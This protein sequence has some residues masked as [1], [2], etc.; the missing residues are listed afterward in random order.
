MNANQQKLR[1]AIKK[2]IEDVEKYSQLAQ[3]YKTV[4]LVSAVKTK[5][6]VIQKLRKLMRGKAEFI[7][8]K[9]V[10]LQ[11]TLE[12]IGKTELSKMLEQPVYLVYTNM[13]P[14][15]FFEYLESNK[16]KVYAI[17][18]D[19]AP[20]DILIEKGPT[21]LQPGPVLSELKGAGLEVIIDKGK[22]SIKNDKVVVKKGE[23][24][25]KSVANVLR[26][27]NI[28]P[29]EIGARYISAIKDNMLF[30][31][32][33]LQTYSKKNVSDYLVAMSQ[34]ALNLSCNVSYYTKQNITMLLAKAVRDAKGLSYS[35]DLYT[36][37]HINSI[38]AKAK[39]Q[40]SAL[41]PYVKNHDN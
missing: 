7:M 30:T 36:D 40:G 35:Q 17:E 37:D 33:I 12:K 3:N 10:V 20:N 27:L 28:K 11:K 23:K 1:R 2:K 4:C 9:K 16:E 29:L 21:E 13:N 6:R 34:Q 26:L 15:E 32:D 14:S 8:A 24:I 18:G 22:I 31:S 5:A 25:S 39:M 41:E 38:L 19:I